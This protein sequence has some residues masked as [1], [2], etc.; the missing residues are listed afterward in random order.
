M[1]YERFDSIP[2][3]HKFRF[4]KLISG[5]TFEVRIRTTNE[6]RSSVAVVSYDI[7]NY[8]G[9]FWTTDSVILLEMPFFG[10]RQV[11]ILVPRPSFFFDYS[12]FAWSAKSVADMFFMILDPNL[13]WHADALLERPLTW[14]GNQDHTDVFGCLDSGH[15]HFRLVSLSLFDLYH[16][17]PALGQLSVRRR[18]IGIFRRWPALSL[19]ERIDFGISTS[20][21]C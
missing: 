13:T 19:P 16:Q 8:S 3:V 17:P 1:A 5:G 2:T 7:V 21:L 15:D 20:N 10:G 9:R 6:R 4:G 12:T 18:H 11:L 14:G